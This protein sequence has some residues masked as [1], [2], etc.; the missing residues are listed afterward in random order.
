[1]IAILNLKKKIDFW[2]TNLLIAKQ[3]FAIL[4]SQNTVIPEVT[5]K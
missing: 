3:N 1:M 4:A 5:T 2:I